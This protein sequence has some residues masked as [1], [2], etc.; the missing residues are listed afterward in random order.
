V[1]FVV[2]EGVLEAPADGN[3]YAFVEVQGD[4]LQ[5]TGKGIASSRTLQL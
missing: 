3:A 1:H 2:L 4:K 5:I